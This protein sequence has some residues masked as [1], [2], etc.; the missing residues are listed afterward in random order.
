MSHDENVI[1][2]NK[3][4][5]T[6]DPKKAIRE[7]EKIRKIYERVESSQDKATVEVQT[8]RPITIVFFGDSHIGGEGTLHDFVLDTFNKVQNTEGAFMIPMGDSTDNFPSR[9]DPAD[10]VVS[11]EIQDTIY[12]KLAEEL[13]S[14]ILTAVIGNHEHFLR[15]SGAMTFGNYF[16]DTLSA[17]ILYNSGL[18]DLKVGDIDYKLWLVHRS[19]YYSFLNAFHCC[20]RER[21]LNCPEADITVVAHSHEIGTQSFRTGHLGKREQIV[22]IRSGTA[23][24]WDRW[25]LSHGYHPADI[26][27]PAII[28][29]PDKKHMLPFD[30]YNDALAV[31]KAFRRHHGK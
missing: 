29:F 11:P 28:L 3:K 14:S 30:D 18:L 17:P 1:F 9:L 20:Q 5:R 15:K 25:G 8:H 26:G 24:A 22:N 2:Q 16:Y 21:Q 23:K 6:I 12:K 7:I 10:Q 13:D 4:E 19:R 31:N 27:F